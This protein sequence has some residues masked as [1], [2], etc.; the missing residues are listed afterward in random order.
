MARHVDDNQAAR[1]A[2][3]ADSDRVDG[4]DWLRQLSRAADLASV[5]T[6]LPAAQLQFPQLDILEPHVVSV[7]LQADE[8]AARKVFHRF[9][10]FGCRAIQPFSRLMP[11]VAIDR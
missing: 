3:C 6:K 8:S 9:R 1:L 2:R 5:G 7:V 11:L 4:C 10:E